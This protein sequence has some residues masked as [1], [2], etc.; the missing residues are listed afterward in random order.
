MVTSIPISRRDD[1]CKR[2]SRRSCRGGMQRM[3]LDVFR[4]LACFASYTCV[5]TLNRM[6]RTFPILH[7]APTSGRRS[8]DAHTAYP[9]T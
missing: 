1:C 6:L 7:A 2:G 8:S 4:A 3:R 5:G 9:S